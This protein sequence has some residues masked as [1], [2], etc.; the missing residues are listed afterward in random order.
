MAVGNSRA[1]LRRALVEIKARKRK[2][3]R[4][5]RKVYGY[6]AIRGKAK[7]SRPKTNSEGVPEGGRGAGEAREGSEKALDS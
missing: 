3:E 5:R 4:E 6:T 7:K 1:I 2:E